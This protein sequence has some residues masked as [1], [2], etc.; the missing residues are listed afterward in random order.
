MDKGWVDMFV[1]VM[2]A[3]IDERSVVNRLD[4]ASCEL[5]Q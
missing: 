2:R 4:A 3:A 5:C 1:H